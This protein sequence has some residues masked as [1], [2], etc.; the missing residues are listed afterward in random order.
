MA[1]N[2]TLRKLNKNIIFFGGAIIVVFFVFIAVFAPFITIYDPEAIDMMSIFLPPSDKHFF[3]TDEL[4]RDVF[5]RVVYGSRIS[6]FVGIVAVGISVAAGVVLGLISGYFGGWAD[7][8]IMRFTDVMLCFPS[9]FLILAVIAFLNPSIINVMVVI[10]LTGWMGVARLVR[11]ETMSVKNREYII[12]AHLAGLSH[13]RIL[14]KHIL[15]NVLAPVFV[16]AA[17]GMAGAILTESSL[18]FLGLGVQP[19]TP[20]WGNIL[21]SGKDNIM[22]AWWLSFFPG[23]AIL[24]TALGYNMLGEGLRDIIDPKKK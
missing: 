24:L 19:P 7:S 20:S 10:G 17:L 11:A 14:F 21:T 15:P 13:A 8:I 22:F 2:S 4:G 12:A 6:L 18:S 1:I 23:V 9:F 3:G 16:T 5:S